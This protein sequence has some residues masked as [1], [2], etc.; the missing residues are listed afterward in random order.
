M[1]LFR[2][3]RNVKRLQDM[4]ATMRNNRINHYNH[5]ASY[6]DVRIQINRTPLAPRTL[7]QAQNNRRKNNRVTPRGER[8]AGPTASNRRS[9]GAAESIWRRRKSGEQK[10]QGSTRFT[11]ALRVVMAHG[12]HV[13]KPSR[14]DSQQ[15]R[16][17]RCT[18]PWCRGARMQVQA[19]KG[20]A[21]Q[22][23]F[24][25]RSNPA[26]TGPTYNPQIT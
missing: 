16:R 14:P 3:Q 13:G 2:C 20:T 24:A 12:V 9:P 22:Q 4:A 19:L 21:T 26:L 8:A 25:S 17:R 1:R 15:L 5:A 7:E 23:F 6:G 18:R 11:P 10:M